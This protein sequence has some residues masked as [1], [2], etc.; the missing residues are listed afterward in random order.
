MMFLDNKNDIIIKLIST[1]LYIDMY[2]Y[3][4]YAYSTFRYQYTITNYWVGTVQTDRQH[5]AYRTIERSTEYTTVWCWLGECAVLVGVTFD[6][7]ILVFTVCVDCAGVCACGCA[8]ACCDCAGEILFWCWAVCFPVR[9]LAFAY[10]INR[11]NAHRAVGVADP[12]NDAAQCIQLTRTDLIQHSIHIGCITIT[13][14]AI[15]CMIIKW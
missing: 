6:C 9:P 7:R 14:S 15:T 12:L 4:C 10:V 1:V 5:T 3:V 8:V 2:M 11:C 13:H